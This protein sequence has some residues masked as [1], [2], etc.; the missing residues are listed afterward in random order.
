[1]KKRVETVGIIGGGPSG[2][3]LA[4]LLALRGVEA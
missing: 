3:T 4:A 2:L 1:M